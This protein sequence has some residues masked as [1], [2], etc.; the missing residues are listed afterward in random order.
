M[1][2]R[3][4]I[5]AIVSFA[6]VVGVVVIVKSRSNP[7]PVYQG[8][9]AQYWLTQ[10]FTTNQQTALQA[11]REMGTN[12]SPVLV[13]AF[14]KSDGLWDHW[15]QGNYPKLPARARKHLAPPIRD[16][17][18]WN[19]VDLVLLNNQ[20]IRLPLRDV[21]RLLRDK[22][23]DDA[24]GYV[25]RAVA[26]SIGPKNKDYVPILIE[27]LDDPD[28]GIRGMSASMLGRIGQEAKAAVPGLTNALKDPSD[29]VRMEAARALWRIDRQTNTAAKVLREVANSQGLHT[30]GWAR[31][32]L[33]EV[34]PN[35]PSVIPLIGELLQDKN[36]GL[37]MSAAF[38][39]GKYGPAAREAVPLLINLMSDSDQEL[40]QR[41]LESLKKIDPEVAAKYEKR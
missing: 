38:V 22:T 14:E 4:A 26:H 1:K 35:D 36:R 27:C 30:R 13:N 37:R 16:R 18:L 6:L 31:I 10:V 24:R 19:S 28:R 11:F 3:I 5:I 40:R 20:N 12:A 39:I 29:N 17:D 2:G 15:Y 21:E 34:V 8:Q 7:G 41:A 32:S 25:S 23:H 33:S 9:T